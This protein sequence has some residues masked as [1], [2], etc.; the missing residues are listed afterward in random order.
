MLLRP[1]IASIVSHPDIVTS[2]CQYK[3]GSLLR[4]V[5]YPH[6]MVVDDSMHQEYSRL[7]LVFVVLIEFAW[8]PLERQNV[9]IVSLDG[10]SL[11]S[12]AILVR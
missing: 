7:L 9:A 6:H 8:D 4:Q 12:E 2:V 10:V 3:G 11:Y 5:D 1:S